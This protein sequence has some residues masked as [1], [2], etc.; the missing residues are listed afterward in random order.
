MNF[1]KF[2]LDDD[3]M[4]QEGGDKHGGYLEPNLDAARQVFERAVKVPYQTRRSLGRCI[5]SMGREIKRERE[6]G[7]EDEI[8]C[9]IK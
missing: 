9:I 6:R 7:G 1:E 5:V 3:A 8:R 4:Q 2:Q